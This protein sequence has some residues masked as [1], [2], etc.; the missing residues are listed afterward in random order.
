M[1]DKLYLLSL[2][3]YFRNEYFNYLISKEFISDSEIEIIDNKKP[4]LYI[5]LAINKER[6]PSCLE[7]IKNELKNV[8][9]PNIKMITGAKQ[10]CIKELGKYCDF[11]SF[12]K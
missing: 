8:E 3:N 4:L 9:L 1:G 12:Y 5:P 7:W 11:L 2:L 6:Y 10:I